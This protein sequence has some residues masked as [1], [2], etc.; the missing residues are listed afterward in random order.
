MSRRLRFTLNLLLLLAL[1]ACVPA[2]SMFTAVPTTT[3]TLSPAAVAALLPRDNAVAGW[4]ISEPAQTFNHDNLFNLVDGQADSFFVYNF[5]QATTQRYRNSSGTLLN[6]E[7]WQL[8]TP[9]DAYGLFTFNRAGA[10]AAIGREGDSDPGRRLTFWQNCY[11]V[12]LNANEPVPDGDLT[13]FAKAIVG[14]L[15]SNGEPP[16]LVGRLPTE[17][18]EPRSG[19]FFHAALSLQ[20]ELWLSDDNILGLSQDTNGIVAR[21]TLGNAP[22]HLLL[23]HY[24]AAPLAA[25]GLKAL[26][27]AQGVDL[28]AADARQAWLGAVFG[29]ADVAPAKALLANALTGAQP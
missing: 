1:A 12:H 29:K 7:V 24:P 20:N 8:A 2:T 23:I 26:G 14:A 25:A 4:T 13:A 17:G 16:A 6:V 10:P 11:Y 18:L 3:A 21:Y 15:P 28:L 5:V 19:I 27:Q 9:V 22:V